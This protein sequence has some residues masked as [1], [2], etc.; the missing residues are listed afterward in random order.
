MGRRNL[1]DLRSCYVVVFVVG[2]VARASSLHI[3]GCARP[4]SGRMPKKLGDCLVRG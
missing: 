3:D 4:A 1:E 2:T